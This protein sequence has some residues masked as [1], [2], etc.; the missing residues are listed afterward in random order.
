M[1]KNATHKL[2]S[3]LTRA[4]AAAK[5]AAKTLSIAAHTRFTPRS[6]V[7]GLALCCLA[8]TAGAAG[9][10]KVTVLSALGQPLRAEVAISATREELSGMKAQLA[11]ADAF[12]Q[13]GIEYASTLL[14][15]KFV[16]DKNAQ[17]SPIIK[18]SSDRPVNDPFIDMLLELSWPSG[19]LVRE[20][21]FLLDPPEFSGQSA[22][23]IVPPALNQSNAT[24]AASA[25]KLATEVAR[26]ATLDQAP[27][28]A[29]SNK[30]TN[31][32][33]AS[34]RRT[35][36]RPQ[37][38]P[39]QRRVAEAAAEEGA[40]QQETPAGTTHTVKKGETLTQIASAHKTESVSLDQMLVAVLRANQ[41]AF[42]GANMNRLKAGKILRIPEPSAVEAV[43]PESAQKTVLT[44][45]ADWNAYR[46]KLAGAAERSVAKDKLGQQNTTGKITAKVEDKAAPALAPKDQ[47]KV[48]KSE[49]KSA[50]KAG[51]A[52]LIAKD[53]AIKEANERLVSLEKNVA[54][55]QQLLALKNQNLAELEKQAAKRAAE[56]APATSPA[57]V[58][59]AAATAAAANN[60]SAPSNPPPDEAVSTTAPVE[61]AKVTAVAAAPVE[62]TATPAP[63]PAPVAAVKPVAPKVDTPPVAVDDASS[64]LTVL[65]IVQDMLADKTLLLDGAAAAGGAGLLA[66]A[67][68]WF[69][70]RR[71]KLATGQERADNK[72][73]T[74]PLE[75]NTSGL[76]EL[77]S[78][79]IFNDAGGRSVDTERTSVLMTDFS[80]EGAGI[81]DTDEVDPVAEADVYMAYGRDLQAEEILLE[82]KQKDPT[83]HAIH[84]KLLEIYA[85]R[86]AL[87]PFEA[88]ALELHEKTGGVGEEW[89]K[90]FAMGNKLDPQNPLFGGMPEVTEAPAFNPSATIVLATQDVDANRAAGANRAAQAVKK[91]SAEPDFLPEIQATSTVFNGL[92]LP[93]EANADASSD[94]ASATAY[95]AENLDFDLG[96][97]KQEGTHART[98]AGLEFEMPS[99]SAASGNGGAA[100]AAEA[101]PDLDFNLD[102]PSKAEL[103]TPEHTQSPA[104]VEPM[105]T[106]FSPDAFSLAEPEAD[107]LASAPA[108][109]SAS[110]STPKNSAFDMASIDL[111]LE[112]TMLHPA[113]EIEAEAKFAE[114]APRTPETDFA[115]AQMATAIDTP[116]SSGPPTVL[117]FDI[118]PDEEV[119]TKLELAKAYQE[120]GDSEGAR[121]LLAEVLNEGSAEQKQSAQLILSGLA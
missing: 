69:K 29:E 33:R 116:D 66:A 104:P 28:L 75:E 95:V 94:F 23:A 51:E 113:A 58:A 71:R 88:V 86:K 111:N 103:T 3:R 11:S 109:A 14:G 115:S 61:P 24:P 13:A 36:A 40:R 76:V 119:N 110:A 78:N 16:L 21:T 107:V 32:R 90:A 35:S 77:T 99:A 5:T 43:S 65:T 38:T 67:L 102:T 79:S 31:E 8:P 91:A 41:D 44:Q 121:E 64:E 25:S 22:R 4:R 45:A 81:I 30:L 92:E 1:A 6:I 117:D 55:L 93:Q 2:N 118:S 56:K 80:Q 47:V 112:A 54:D 120:M 96:L 87:S 17:G 106:E 101:F 74:T 108:P 70:R 15:I 52:D 62:P 89:Q 73:T 83:R 34:E 98:V 10:G 20:Y 68:L 49:S 26:E 50:G 12:R 46:G 97:D 57:P 19:R 48:S 63:A 7:A 105:L 42:D 82:A 84:L 53:K 39:R 72:A 85:N 100:E 59:A 60:V 114:A 9:L 37:P 18:L 27:S